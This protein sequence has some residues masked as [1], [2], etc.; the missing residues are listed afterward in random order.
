MERITFGLSGELLIAHLA[1][2]GTVAVLDSAGIAAFLHHDPDSQSYEP[3]VEADAAVGEIDTA[4]RQS[5]IL[6]E[7]IVETDIVAGRRG[8]DRRS[9]I[10]ARASYA[11]DPT[12]AIPVVARRAT[13][14][15]AAERQGN[16]VALRV[17][18]GIGALAIWGPRTVRVSEGATALDGVIGNHTSDF[19]R[20]VLRPMRAA[21]AALDGEV[22]AGL[23]MPAA[24]DG[25]P[26]KTGWAPPGTDVAKVHQWLAAIGLSLLPV[27]H[28]P[29]GRSVTPAC[30]TTDRPR[31]HGITL[32][33][34]AHPTS[35]P[36]LRAVLAT[37]ALPQITSADQGGDGTSGQAASLLRSFGVEEVAI[38]ERQYQSGAGSSVAFQ[39]RRGQRCGL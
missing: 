13:L 34:I 15:E 27:A 36:R 12:E 11:R 28:R 33:L 2:Y 31:R 7:E 1:A 39:F 6:C 9:V 35:L 26:D 37:A 4:I 38:F 10:W 3:I 22:V 16:Q 19:V 32:P 29:L 17:L 30:W 14:V 23:G 18:S 5:A 25:E 8:N 20:G 21:V 24:H